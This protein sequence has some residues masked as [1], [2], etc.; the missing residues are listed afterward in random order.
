MIKE[1][2]S[3]IPSLS[4]EY[5]LISNL[6]TFQ[7]FLFI[8]LKIQPNNIKT[9]VSVPIQI[10]SL[11]PNSGWIFACA[12]QALRKTRGA[13]VSH[14]VVSSMCSLFCLFLTFLLQLILPVS[15]EEGKMSGN[16]AE[17]DAVC[18]V[19]SWLLYAVCYDLCLT[20]ASFFS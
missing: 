3:G 13:V 5:I 8:R 10:L 9:S 1:T 15:V 11:F 17:A 14:D 19:L 20:L 16:Q 12:R 7:S 18:G 4:L 2:L 6:L